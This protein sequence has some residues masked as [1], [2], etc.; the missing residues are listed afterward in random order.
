[1]IAAGN[2]RMTAVAP[3]IDGAPPFSEFAAGLAAEQLLLQRC[4]ICATV[5][6][7]HIRCDFCLARTL[8]WIPSAGSGAIHAF[9][10]MHRAY[11][12]AFADRIPY[13]VGIVELDDGPRIVAA[14]EI[15]R[16]RLRAGLRVRIAWDRAGAG[17]PVCFVEDAQ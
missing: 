15:E 9:A 2:V 1:M 13:A 5:Q 17:R 10:I 16:A 12:P 8:T 4:T 14:F 11:H 3:Q 6:L 7:G